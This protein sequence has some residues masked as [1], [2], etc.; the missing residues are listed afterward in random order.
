MV[1]TAVVA[2]VS[3][4]TAAEWSPDRVCNLHLSPPTAEHSTVQPGIIKLENISTKLIKNFTNFLIKKN[5]LVV[6]NR[7]PCVGW[8]SPTLAEN[9]VC[10]LW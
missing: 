5:Y 6:V 10:L 9:R 3:P 2:P 8:L 1:G 4:A 7:K